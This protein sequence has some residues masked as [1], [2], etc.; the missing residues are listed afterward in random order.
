MTPGY[1]EVADKIGKHNP[2]MQVMLCAAFLIRSIQNGMS[3]KEAKLFIRDFLI[4]MDKRFAGSDHKYE[5]GALSNLAVQYM[6]WIRQE[7]KSKGAEESVMTNFSPIVTYDQM[8]QKSDSITKTSKPTAEN[9]MEFGQSLEKHLKSNPNMDAELSQ[10]LYDNL[11]GIMCHYNYMEHS[12]QTLKGLHEWYLQRIQKPNGSSDYKDYYLLA[13]AYYQFGNVQVIKPQ[14]DFYK[15]LARILDYDHFEQT[16]SQIIKNSIL[17]PDEDLSG[18]ESWVDST[19]D[20]REDSAVQT[21]LQNHSAGNLLDNPTRGESFRME[22]YNLNLLYNYIATHRYMKFDTW[23]KRVLT[24]SLTDAKIINV[25]FLKPK[26]EAYELSNEN[27]VVPFT[28]MR[29]WEVKFLILEP[30]A[31]SV[32]VRETIE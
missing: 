1:E 31:D 20:D 4:E 3:Y 15:S 13:E 26:V 16:V 30:N 29:D 5:L 18:L 23:S 11:L 17:A 22:V 24:T 25:N 6:S 19:L 21:L 9:F 8:I 10:M 28:D 12:G 32:F 14:L 2:I 27:I 7:Q